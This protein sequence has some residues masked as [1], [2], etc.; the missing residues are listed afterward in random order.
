[1]NANKR[2]QEEWPSSLEVFPMQ[3]EMH[4]DHAALNQQ[5]QCGVLHRRSLEECVSEIWCPE[6]ASRGAESGLLLI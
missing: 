6:V 4:Q 1:M 2:W 3:D 5:S